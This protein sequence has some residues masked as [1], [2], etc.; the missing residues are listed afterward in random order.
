[1]KLRQLINNFHLLTQWPADISESSLSNW[2]R[3]GRLLSSVELYKLTVSLHTARGFPVS[4]FAHAEDSAC[5]SPTT[6]N[7]GFLL[8]KATINAAVLLRVQLCREHQLFSCLDFELKWLNQIASM[9]NRD[10]L[11]YDFL[12]LFFFFVLLLLC[13]QFALPELAS[14]RAN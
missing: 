10:S 1:M 13:T 9:S 12:Y 6:P 14:R 7:Y 8:G 4:F 11:I 3:Q 2:Q 5:E